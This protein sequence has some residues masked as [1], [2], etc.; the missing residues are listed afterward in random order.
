VSEANVE[1]VRETYDAFWRRRDP[2]ASTAHLSPDI[3]WVTPLEAEPR[4][5][6]DEVAE[7]FSDWLSTFKDHEIEYEFRDAGNRVVVIIHLS[8]KGR[9]SGVE[10]EMSAGQVWTVRDG[11]LVR[12][13][14]FR[15]PE[16][17]LEAAGLGSG[18]H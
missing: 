13:E 6:P 17:A 8:G 15:T 9:E 7:F 18:G 3:E 4:R 1:L 14:M 16:E 12:M 10:V 2:E 5:G 11:A